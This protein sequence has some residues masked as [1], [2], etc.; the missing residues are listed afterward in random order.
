MLLNIVIQAV[1]F[2]LFIT[3]VVSLVDSFGKPS[4]STQLELLVGQPFWKLN[5]ILLAGEKKN[6]YLGWVGSTG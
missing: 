5:N 1:S 3:K 4:E 2:C 6:A